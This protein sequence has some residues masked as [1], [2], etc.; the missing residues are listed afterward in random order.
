MI[1][2]A[3]VAR[4][5]VIAQPAYQVAATVAREH[6][7]RLAMADRSSICFI[8]TLPAFQQ[9]KEQAGQ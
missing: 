3:P 7:G 4:N 9:E 6:G 5:D 8:I 2:D 1:D